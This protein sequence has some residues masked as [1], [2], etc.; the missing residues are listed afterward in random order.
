MV[1]ALALLSLYVEWGVD[2]ALDEAPHDRFAESP[3]PTRRPDTPTTA[4]VNPSASAPATPRARIAAQSA[5]PTTESQIAAA[6]T[7]AASCATVE[8]LTE[9]LRTF[10]G[11]ALRQ[12]ATNTLLPRGPV[13]AAVMIIGEAPEAEE[14]RSGIALAGP[15]GDITKRMF[16][17]IGLGIED[18][19]Y[20]PVVPWR[21]PGGRPPSEVEVRICLPFVRR[22]MALLAPRRVVLLGATPARYILDTTT[23]MARLRGRWQPVPEAPGSTAI[24]AL[25][26]RHPAQFSASSAARREGWNDL[27]MLRADLDKETP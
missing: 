5:A 17:T 1:D 22:A 12:T 13:G 4:P 9:A 3:P 10:D 24:R 7:L 21:P 25:V 20:A 14:D 6:E 23:A 11:C 27:L 18:L 19:A 15:T 8:A 2:T 16:Q 26:I